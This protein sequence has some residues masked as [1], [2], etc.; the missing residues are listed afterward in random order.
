MDPAIEN[1]Q[2]LRSLLQEYRS[3]LK[4]YGE[5]LMRD[6]SRLDHRMATLFEMQLW[7]HETFDARMGCAPSERDFMG[8]DNAS[9]A[10]KLR[11]LSSD[12]RSIPPVDGRTSYERPFVEERRFCEYAIARIEEELKSRGVPVEK[13]AKRSDPVESVTAKIHQQVEAESRLRRQCEEDVEKYPD[14]EE[15]IRRS[16]RRAI[17]ALREQS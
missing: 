1:D 6:E 17:D 2:R 7:R 16:Y 4:Q 10:A 8:V 3:M 14:Q 5:G 11:T 9:L 13:P 12:L 15:S